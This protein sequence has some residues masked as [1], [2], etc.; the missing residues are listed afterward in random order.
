MW[1]AAGPLGSGRLGPRAE[2]VASRTRGPAR[3]VGHSRCSAAGQTDGSVTARGGRSYRQGL[4]VLPPCGLPSSPRSCSRHI[5]GGPVGLQRGPF[6]Q[7]SQLAVRAA[8]IPVPAAGS[9][10]NCRVTC[11]RQGG[12]PP[13]FF[14][15]HAGTRT[16][17]PRATASACH[18][19]RHRSLRTPFASDTPP[20]PG[21][22]H[23][24][25]RLAGDIGEPPPPARSTVAKSKT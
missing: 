17:V 12:V 5:S 22:A 19:T 21:P 25:H 1:A 3:L 11:L 15:T 6:V 16:H 2:R 4:W 10:V 23:P 8:G 7:G 9:A 24:G 13:A 18:T 14:Q 20:L